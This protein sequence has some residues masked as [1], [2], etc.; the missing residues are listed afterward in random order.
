MRG[1]GRPLLILYISLAKTWRLRSWIETKPS[2]SNDS[3]NSDCLLFYIVL[4]H[5]YEVGLFSYCFHDC[6]TSKSMDSKT[7]CLKKGIH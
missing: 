3:L 7:L 5:L 2:F 6:E 4:I 1:V